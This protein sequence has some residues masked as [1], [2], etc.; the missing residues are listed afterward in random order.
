[1]NGGKLAS[2]MFD[3]GITTDWMITDPDS[4]IDA[5]LV[6]VDAAMDPLLAR[7]WERENETPVYVE[8]CHFPEPDES[9]ASDLDFQ[10]EEKDGA[11]K[12]VDVAAANAKAAASKAKGGSKGSRRPTA[13]EAAVPTP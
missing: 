10:D 8:E 9:T 5:R 6:S 3:M 4:Y 7:C 2:F 11:Q 12:K 13:Q 1:M